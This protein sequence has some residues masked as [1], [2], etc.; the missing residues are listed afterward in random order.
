MSH[1]PLFFLQKSC[2]GTYTSK[3]PSPRPAFGQKTGHTAT[4]IYVYVL[5][6]LICP[7]KQGVVGHGRKKNR[8]YVP[9]AILQYLADAF[10]YN[11]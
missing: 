3:T 2:L 8:L 5:R 11:L 1:F 9:G 4:E 10:P 7:I 6:R